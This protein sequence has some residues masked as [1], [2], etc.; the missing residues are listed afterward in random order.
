MSAF[1][2]RDILISL[3]ASQ[4][5]LI[6]LVLRK[7]LASSTFAISGTIRGLVGRLENL[8]TEI[9]LLDD[10]DLEGI[11]E[12]EDEL[13]IDRQIREARK[14]ATLA[15]TLAEKLEM[16]RAIK[17]LESTRTTERRRPLRSPGPDRQPPR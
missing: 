10:D 3:P 5:T 11:E 13:R 9:A 1:L 14:T 12:L 6:T 8:S 16:Q 17:T 15:G 2:Q 7:L 4:R